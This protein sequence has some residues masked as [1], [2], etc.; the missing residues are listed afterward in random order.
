LSLSPLA[1]RIS[2]V[3]SASLMLS[4]PLGTAYTPLQSD[5]KACQ[6]SSHAG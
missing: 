2:V 4:K 5:S 6:C 1:V 3:L